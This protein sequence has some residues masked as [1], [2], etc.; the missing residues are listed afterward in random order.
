MVALSSSKGE[1]IALSAAVQE[2]CLR[3]TQLLRDTDVVCG[4]VVIF[5]DN[6]GTI[7]LFKNPEIKAY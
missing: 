3:L 1:H 2:D 6:Q 4:P 7:S 5:E